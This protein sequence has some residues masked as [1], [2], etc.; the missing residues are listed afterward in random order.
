MSCTKEGSDIAGERT[1]VVI[2][3]RGRGRGGKKGDGD[4]DGNGDVVE[5]KRKG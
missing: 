3:G 2:R 4:G 1:R 5:G